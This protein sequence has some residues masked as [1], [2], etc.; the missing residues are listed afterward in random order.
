MNQ[1]HGVYYVKKQTWQL[2]HLYCPPV[3]SKRFNVSFIRDLIEEINMLRD[4]YSNAEFLI[5]GDFN[6]RIGEGQVELPHLF[7][8]WENCNAKSYNFGDKRRSKD[9]NC[10]SVR[11]LSF[12]ETNNFQILNGNFGSDTRGDFTFINKLDSSVIDYALAYEGLINNRFKNGVEII[13]SHMSLIGVR[14]YNRRYK[15]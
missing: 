1:L 6:Y 2:S 10:K 5:M 3:N 8:F 15:Q 7:D 4:K 9:K 13:S 12:C 11:N 14:K